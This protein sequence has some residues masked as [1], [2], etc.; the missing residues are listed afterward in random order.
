MAALKEIRRNP[1][2]TTRQPD[3]RLGLLAIAYVCR[4]IKSRF[5]HHFFFLTFS[6]ALAPTSVSAPILAFGV[7]PTEWICIGILA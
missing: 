2:S 6:P 5:L 1:R 4:A 3:T 7:C